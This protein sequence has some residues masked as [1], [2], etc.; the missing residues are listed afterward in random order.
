[1]KE[2][3]IDLM[4]QALSAYT[5]EHIDRYFADVQ[6]DGL[7]EHGFPRLTANIGILIAH[8]RRKDLLPRFLQM[9][10]FCCQQIPKVKAAN[11]FS[12]REMIFC[13]WEIEENRV[14]DPADIAR[15]KDYLANITPET[16]YSVFARTPTDGYR[17][18]A[19]FTGVSEFFR[20]KAGLC[21]VQEFID[22]QFLQQAQWLDENGMYEDNI[23][24][25][26]H[27]P[28]MYDIV[29][30]LLYAIAF[31]QGY[32]GPYR[33]VIDA[34]LK[35]AGLLTLAMQSPNGEVPFGGRSSQFI[36]NE[37]SLMGILEYEAKR[38]AREGSPLAGQFKA[39]V[40]RA[41]AVTEHWLS[42]RPIRH[43]KNRFP[44][45][46]GF[47]CEHYAYF[48]KY[49]ISV[50]SMLY[51]AYLICDDT[52]PMA[53]GEDITPC[54]AETA[55]N[56]H[57]VFAK[58]GGYGIEFDWNGDPHYDASGLGRVHWT[59][60]PSAICLSSPC[61]AEPGFKVDIA[62]MA[63]SLCAA[64]PEENDWLLAAGTAVTYEQIAC[65]TDDKT[66]NI[67]LRCNF[68]DGRSVSEQYTVSEN[69]V[70]ITIQ[71]A[72][73]IGYALPAFAFDGEACPTITAEGK[74]LTI[75]YGGWLCRYATDGEIIDLGKTAANRNGHYK[76]FLA[77]GQNS[78]HINI[79]I[80]K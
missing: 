22:L 47:G 19:L 39:A 51:N 9:M 25:V 24:S 30:R 32:Q 33:E 52:I 23:T 29:P 31:D 54:V 27:Q 58:A 45:E 46:T 53:V 59:N 80:T 79:T 56:F 50:A 35:K 72:G 48:D 60:A 14:A 21:Q 61:P 74:T 49:M 10:E 71:G 37:A 11:D 12:V 55:P 73:E 41:M 40:Q 66:A 78:L 69:G 20:Q 17:N 57:K 34:K 64:L 13:L 77:T 5:D 4:E 16:C 62:P 43:I 7:T 28:V 8:G 36:H 63:L 6:R 67:S 65:S 18:W 70:E 75:S 15:W 76:A 3:Y 2:Q 26:A 44:T 42:K 38:Y 1:M 68:P